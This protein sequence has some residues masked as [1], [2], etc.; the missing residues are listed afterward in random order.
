[1]ERVLPDAPLGAWRLANESARLY[2]LAMP[3]LLP[4][5]IPA[6]LAG[7]LPDLA[8]NDDSP[9]LLAAVLR[10]V[11]MLVYLWLVVAVQD[12]A[13]RWSLGEGSSAAALRAGAARLGPFF[14][15]SLL[16]GLIVMVPL[17][18]AAAGA[19]ALYAGGRIELAVAVIAVALVPSGYLGVRY[20][21]VTAEAVL[22]PSPVMASLRLSWQ[23][24]RG[25]F[26]HISIVYAVLFALVIL[27]MLV[28]VVVGA[29]MVF[30]APALAD[31]IAAF[32]SVLLLSTFLLPFGAVLLALLW[33]DL[34][35]RAG[36]ASP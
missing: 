2:S 7:T 19:Y 5:A 29:V 17:L 22:R 32:I 31:F 18:A 10:L 25:H 20:A 27:I 11:V 26:W 34:R 33:N 24:T 21:L 28:T 16:A 6:A 14:G 23:L 13:Y 35:L 8:L 36:D 1:M 15:A 4:L 30:V 3:A 12:R 9:S